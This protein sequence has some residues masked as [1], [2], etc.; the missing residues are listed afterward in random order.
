MRRLLLTVAVF[1]AACADAAESPVPPAPA[2]P[3]HVLANDR[4]RMTLYLPDAA[5]GFYRG[6]RFDGSG[7]IA[8]VEAGGHVFY[9]PWKTPHDPSGNDCAIGPAEEFGMTRPVG[10]DEAAPGGLF[11]KIGVG[12]LE[13]EAAADPA[14]KTS[15]GFWKPYAIAR[16]GAWK[17]APAPGAVTFEQEL[18]APGGYGYRYV[19][20]IVLAPGADGFAI[21]RRL[22]NTGSKPLVTD[23]YNHNFTIIDDV[24]IGTDYR[25]VYDVAPGPTSGEPPAFSVEAKKPHSLGGFAEVRGR[26]LVFTAALPPGKAIHANLLGFPGGAPYAFAI[27][28]RKTGAAIRVRG[29]RPL[30]RAAVY[31]VRTAVCPEPF[32]DI[33]LA[34][35]AVLEWKTEYLLEARLPAGAE[36]R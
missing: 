13:K 36:T 20:R 32:I 2:F 23:H 31:A 26:A 9:G 16:P 22:E 4:V 24:P 6:P 1:L 30:A 7:M 5:A 29:E 11:P 28:N 19:K 3:S 33:D 18:A 10:Y 27:E 25:V 17:I 15:Y 21:E 34:P 8:R 35:G 12:L 14:K